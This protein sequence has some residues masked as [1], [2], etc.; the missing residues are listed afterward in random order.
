MVR[1]QVAP[2]FLSVRVGRI[3][4]GLGVPTACHGGRR[5]QLRLLPATDECVG[6]VL[7]LRAL[8]LL[9][10]IG[11]I[12]IAEAGLLVFEFNRSK[13]T[14]SYAGTESAHQHVLGDHERQRRRL[15][16]LCPLRT[17]LTSALWDQ[18]FTN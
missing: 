12:G 9:H 17:G 4:L 14:T 11:E 1:Q 10:D 13:G 16:H 5:K 8:W 18:R 7:L 6:E 15:V 3:L 2:L